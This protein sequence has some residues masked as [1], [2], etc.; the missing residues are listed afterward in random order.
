MNVLIVDDN[1]DC[2]YLLTALVQQLGHDARGAHSC[3]AALAAVAGFT[4]DL[5]L[6]D[7]GMPGADGYELAVR[8]RCQARLTDARIVALSGYQADDERRCASGIDLHRMK[9]IDLREV[10]RLLVWASSVEARVA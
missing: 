8:L 5:V 3:E 4:P 9:P 10:R 6:L 1:P 7:L 2:V